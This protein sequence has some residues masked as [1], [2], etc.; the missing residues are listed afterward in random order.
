M[1]GIK[2]IDLFAGIGGFRLGLESIGAKCVFS[3]EIDEHAISMYETNFHEN[4]KCDITTLDPAT[5]PDFDILCAGFPCQAFS[6]SGKQ[7]GFEDATRGTL[8]FDIC[9]ILNEKKPPYFILENV[10]NLETHDKGNTLYV[11]LRELNSLGYSVSYKVLN[12][13]DFGTPQNR[14][15]IILVGSRDGRIFDFN[16]VKTNTVASMKGFLDTTGEFEYLSPEEYTLIDNEHVK[17]QPRSGLIFVGYRNKK[18]RTKGVREGTEHLSRVHKQPNRI[19]SSDGIHPTIASQEQSGRYWILHN[20]R[21]RKLTIDECYKFMGFP[22]TFKKIGIR[23]KLYERIGNSVCVPMVASIAKSLKEQFYDNTGAEMTTSELLESLYKESGNI[24]TIDELNLSEQQ[25]SFAKAI[26]DKEET[27]KGVYTVLV[28]S[29]VYKI[30]NPSQDI[31][32]HQANMEGGI[33]VVHS[34]LNT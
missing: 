2:F 4:S 26:V 30:L 23:S 16:K 17:Q 1:N 15:R 13:K 6:I 34:I 12:A 31:R 33:V 22:K 5:I 10:K 8:F 25:L 18:M 20:N 28:T 27:L 11:M 9:R 7:K 3:S 24:K 29:L 32:R 14:E 19:Y 21:V